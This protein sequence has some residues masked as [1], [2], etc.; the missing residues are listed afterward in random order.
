MKKISVSYFAKLQEMSQKEKEEVLTSATKAR[1]L[2]FE[3]K[4]KYRFSLAIEELLLSVNEISFLPLSSVII[5]HFRTTESKLSISFFPL[6]DYLLIL[7]H[8]RLLSKPR[9]L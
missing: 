6:T 8:K 4:Q 3:L 5:P 2:F 7:I 9:G 1:D